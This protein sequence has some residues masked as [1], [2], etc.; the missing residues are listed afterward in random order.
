MRSLIA[1]APR[2]TPAALLLLAGLM[3]LATAACGASR[4]VYERVLHERNALRHE[5]DRARV[6]SAARVMEIAALQAQLAQL[7]AELS[8]RDVRQSEAITE[9]SDLARR[10]DEL[11]ALNTE[12]SGRL[13]SASQSVE[14]LATERGTLS[15]ALE[16]TRLQLEEL[17]QRQTA[18]EDR[19]AQLRDLVT[20][21]KPL[22]DAGR[23]HVV[24]RN[25]R[26][27]IELPTDEFFP[28]DKAT[29]T[30]AGRAAITE[31]ARVL[32]TLPTQRFQIAAHTDDAKPKRPRF[33]STWHLSAA[34]AAEVVKLLVERGVAPQQLSAAGQGA[35]APVAS[36]ATPE[37]RAKN[38]RLEIAIGG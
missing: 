32:C 14:Q 17:R 7:D 26:P 24:A 34:R 2:T 36:N 18:A 10:L 23:V 21:F 28:P 5:V 13:R 38:R 16:Q 25:G 22:V 35:S 20:R 4:P 15:A 6:E 19:S 11:A 33:E 3:G 12:L 31:V 8:A 27:L 1:R 29:L 37:G 30:P 9:H